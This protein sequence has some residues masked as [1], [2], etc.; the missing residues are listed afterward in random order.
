M[1]EAAQ[2]PASPRIVSRPPAIRRP[3][4]MPTGPSTTISPP[5]HLLRRSGR[6]G[7]RHSRCGYARHRPCACGTH[8]PPS[9][10]RRVVCS[11]NRRDVGGRQAGEAVRRQRREIEPLL[12]PRAQGQHERPHG[13]SSLQVEVV[14]AEL[15]AVVA[16]ADPHAPALRRRAGRSRARPARMAAATASPS[17]PVDDDLQH[18]RRRRRSSAVATAP[19]RVGQ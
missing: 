14:R 9:R 6:G 13:S 11:A 8:R 7:R 3:A 1:P 16:G 17:Q 4:W 10:A 2:G 12:G 5:V 18:A 15:A 19:R